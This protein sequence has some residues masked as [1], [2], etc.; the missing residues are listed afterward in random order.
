MAKLEAKVAWQLYPD[1]VLLYG[2][3]NFQLFL[4]CAGRLFL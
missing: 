3:F 4:I 1:T 2:Y